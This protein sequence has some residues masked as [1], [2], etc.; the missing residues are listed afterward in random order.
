MV[1]KVIRVFIPLNFFWW[2]GRLSGH[3]GVVSRLAR[4]ALGGWD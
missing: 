3:Q 1:N 4:V 2:G